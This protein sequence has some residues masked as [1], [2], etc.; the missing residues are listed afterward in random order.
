MFMYRCFL[1]VN[2]LSFILFISSS[3]SVLFDD[4][5]NLKLILSSSIF[6][7]FSLIKVSN[8]DL[9]GLTIDEVERLK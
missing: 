8:Y 2:K 7:L 9:T 1:Y 5:F 3:N 4:F 6:R